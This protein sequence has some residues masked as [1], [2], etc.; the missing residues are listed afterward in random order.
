ME[1]LRGAQR[2]EQ[3]LSQ[4]L[5]AQT[6]QVVAAI[7]LLDEGATVPF[8]ARYRK[9]ATGGLDDGQ[10]RNL[11]D[12]LYY[13][14]EL[15]ERRES[16]L[17]QIDELGKLN[18]ALKKDILLADTKQRLEDLYLPYKVKR[19]SKAQL[20]RE[21][22]LEPLAKTLLRN[23]ELVPEQVAGRF[24]KA[25][26]VVDVT[27]ALEG[28]R[29]LL[30][31]AF[32]EDAELL[33][34]L[35]ANLGRHGF[36]SSRVVKGKGEVG[37]KF[38]DY[39]AYEEPIRR[40]PSHRVLALFRGA[41]EG[42]LKLDLVPES[43]LLED[44]K[45]LPQ[46]VHVIAR[47][48]HLRDKNRP[49]DSWL[50]KSA[51][52]AWK[53]KLH[54]QLRSEFF[55]SLRDRAEAEAIKV[56]GN[57]LEDL[58]LA[59][60]AG[61]RVTLGLD[62]GMRTGCKL[63]VIDGTGKLL[64]FETLYPHP[65]VN[66]FKEALTSLERLCLKYRVALIAIGNGTGSRESD[67]LVAELIKLRPELGLEKTIVSEAGASVYSAS[68]LA[69]SEF[70]ELDVSIRGAVSIARR[71]QDP[72]AEL[73]KI[74]A[75]AI[76]VGQYQHD[77]NQKAL[78]KGLA[79]VVEC[80]VHAVGVDL[81]T[82]SAPLLA[83]VSGLSHTLATNIV[84]YRDSNGRFKNRAS[85]MKVA[86]MGERSY[87]QSAGFLRI[88]AGANPLDAS[89]VHPEAYSLVDK[90]ASSA[91]CGVIDFMGVTGRLN[92]LDPHDF[93]DKQFGLPTVLDIF[94]ELE[95]PGRDPRGS[96][97][98]ASFREGVEDIKDLVQGM[99]LEGVVSN[100]THFGAF[101]DL[102][103][104]QDGLVH[105]SQLSDDYVTDPHDVVKAG[106]VVKVRVLDV[107]QGRRRIALSMKLQVV[108]S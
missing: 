89:A 69:A 65:P 85:L 74:E 92:G 1:P 13:L 43:A 54:P 30:I 90:I 5:K 39:F 6:S 108:E 8:I 36:I 95:K 11:G 73:V 52:C 16:V 45:L 26:L 57:N 102:G 59:P 40:I 9:E 80:C 84:A 24:L 37:A 4:E 19:R 35:R 98:S 66:R 17:T 81:N 106:Q 61:D 103:I 56:F 33:R 41:R 58:L 62:P 10:L 68:E 50:L 93:V 48:F 87:Q 32:S 72:L 100:V 64:A 70:P 38:S 55:A 28:A 14:R 22:G 94:S 67:R 86:R 101:V 107:D 53:Q 27:A 82:A 49:S 15:E 3:I 60:P 44:P 76:G 7:K 104:H 46:A 31:E 75:R 42:V 20:A 91:G 83:H 105:I 23:P 63:A 18:S 77:V 21:A 96:F 47:R 34:E 71:L 29:L 99:L 78:S 79:G 25:D 12:R 51:A 97:R 2:I 88:R